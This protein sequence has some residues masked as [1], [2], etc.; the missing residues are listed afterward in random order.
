MKPARPARRAATTITMLIAILATGSAA[1]IVE[2]A[3]PDDTPGG[4]IVASFEGGW[5][6][7]ADG[8]G[9]A[10]ACL[11]DD[12]GTRCYRSAAEMEQAEHLPT[13]QRALLATC[14]GPLYL[15]TGANSSG[16]TLAIN[17]RGLTL[18]LGPYGFNNVTSS[19]QIGPCSARFYD[20]TTGGTTY[21]GSTN[22][23]AS[24]ASMVSGWDN[25]VGSV[26]IS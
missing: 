25:R 7:L 18:S 23:G 2:A 16:D 5:I 20:T 26:Y 17:T 21:P 4:S 8:W 13:Q 3:S 15:H 24:A 1:P 22:A 9:E 12:D 11:A 19:Y 10:N 6:S 14:G